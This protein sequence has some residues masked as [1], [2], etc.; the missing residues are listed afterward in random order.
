MTLLMCSPDY[1]SIE[2]EIN[3]WMD[4][5]IE[6]NL[7]RTRE[8]WNG[9]YNVLTKD[10][11]ICVELIDP[12]KGSPDMVFTANGGLV[13]G[14][15][16]ISANFRYKERKKEEKYFIEWFKSREY[17]VVV[18][19]ENVVFEGEGDMLS[20]GDT[21]FAG[22]RFRSDITSHE[23]ISGKLGIEVLSLELIDPRFYHLD[24]CFCP[25]PGGEIVY[26]PDAFDSYA[27]SVINDRFD[28][29]KQIKVNESDAAMFACNAVAFEDMVVVNAG[30]DGLKKELELHGYKVFQTDLSEFIKAGGSAKCLT[31]WL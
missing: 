13:R 2:Y 12:V 7:V 31:L 25:L 29:S 16:F 18:S 24:T 3:P 30:C 8:Q 22:Y 27:I 21:F 26:Y 14:D 15:L 9:L 17:I 10:M 1:Y 20:S 28:D 23:W 19:P 5:N 6:A 11:K 4:M